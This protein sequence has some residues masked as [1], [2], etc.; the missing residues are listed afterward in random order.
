MQTLIDQYL[1]AHALA[2]A[3]STLKSEQARLNAVASLIE[4][5]PDALYKAKHKVLKTYALKTLFIRLVDFERWANKSNDWGYQRFV[6]ENARLFKH[7]YKKENVNVTKDH[8]TAAIHGIENETSRAL[9]TALFRNG[10]R[11][12]ELQNYDKFLRLVTGKGGKVRN[13]LSPDVL[14]VNYPNIRDIRRLRADLKRVGLKPHTLRKAAAT[15]LTRGGMQ[16][17]DL[18]Y[19]MGWSSLQT[20]AS[21]L[22]PQQDEKLANLANNILGG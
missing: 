13:L 1:K 7:A 12:S 18:M 8:I 20:A 16:S 21:Y 3:P 17:Q 4:S 10:L 6:Q 9:A 22:Q 11:I 15:L 2:W 19:V 14:P 5:G